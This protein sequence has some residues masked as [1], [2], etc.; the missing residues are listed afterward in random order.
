MQ[1]L[2]SFRLKYYR[3]NGEICENSNLLKKIA[4]EY[5]KKLKDIVKIVYSDFVNKAINK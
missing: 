2:Q 3:K 4:R 1:A 5:M